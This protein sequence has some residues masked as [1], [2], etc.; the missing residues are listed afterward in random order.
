MS[1]NFRIDVHL[2]NLIEPLKALRTNL[3]KR[4]TVCLQN[5]NWCVGDLRRFF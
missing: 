5:L 1:A 3:L 2:E 4:V